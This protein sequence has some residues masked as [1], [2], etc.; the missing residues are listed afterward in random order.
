MKIRL[1]PSVFAVPITAMAGD[2]GDLLRLL[3][4]PS[5]DYPCPYPLCRPNF[6]QDDPRSPKNRQ[7]AVV[8]FRSVHH[9]IRD[10]IRTRHFT[11]CSPLCQ[12]K[13]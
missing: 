12:R 5:A 11:I 8:R 10:W 6:T 1:L 9:T 13:L 2:L 4:E 3:P 7:R